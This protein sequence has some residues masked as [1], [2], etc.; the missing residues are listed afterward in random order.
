MHSWIGIGPVFPQGRT[1]FESLSVGWGSWKSF[2]DGILLL[3]S[4]EWWLHWRMHAE[5]NKLGR[6]G[7][8]VQRAWARA[9][10]QYDRFQSIS[11][12]NKLL[13]KDPLFH[14]V[15]LFVELYMDMWFEI[16]I[17]SLQIF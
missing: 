16:D 4:M 14:S 15:T 8:M 7:Q 17:M 2:G 10:N 11:I 5:H 9:S 1:W 13:P 3:K 6:G 12:N